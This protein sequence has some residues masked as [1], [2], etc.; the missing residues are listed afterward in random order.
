MKSSR[1]FYTLILSL[2]FI[3]ISITGFAQKPVNWTPDHVMQPSELAQKLNDSSTALPVIISVGPGA[4]IPHSIVVGPVQEE[5][6]LAKLT[7][8]LKGLDRKKEVVV[9]CGCCPY[10]HCP[11]VRPAVALLKELK[12]TNYKLLDLPHNMKTDWLDKGYPRVKL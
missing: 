12:F 1:P 8:Q 7:N 9:Y 4:L 10:E 5:E 11:N 3:I 2:A 6:N